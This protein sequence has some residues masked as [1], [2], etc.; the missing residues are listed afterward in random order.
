MQQNR[1]KYINKLNR[2][3][4][5]FPVEVLV[6]KTIMADSMDLKIKGGNVCISS[7]VT[8]KNDF[9]YETFCQIL[10]SI[11]HKNETIILQVAKVQKCGGPTY[12]RKLYPLKWLSHNVEIIYQYIL[13]NYYLH[14]K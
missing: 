3:A 2:Q 5:N 14:Y 10:K 4:D 7:Y 8:E 11:K 13:R 9:H 6:S 1:D 12:Q